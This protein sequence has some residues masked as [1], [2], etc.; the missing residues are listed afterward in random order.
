MHAALVYERNSSNWGEPHRLLEAVAAV[1]DRDDPVVA[2]RLGRHAVRDEVGRLLLYRSA[3]LA[4]E[5]G[6]PLVEGSMAKLFQSE[7]FTAMASDFLDLFGPVGTLPHGA[8]GAVLDG[9]VEHA[10]R[11]STVTTIYGGSSEVQRGIIAEK[12]LGLPRSR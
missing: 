1:A 5:G 6:L 8:A 11:H 3:W 10:F 7:W 2:E 12:G 4:S 9:L